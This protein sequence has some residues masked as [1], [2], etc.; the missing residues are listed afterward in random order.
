LEIFPAL[1]EAN[2]NYRVLYDRTHELSLGVSQDFFKM[3]SISGKRFIEVKFD[4][5]T[6][7]TDKGIIQI[8]FAT[9]NTQAN[10]ISVD[11]KG[12]SLFTDI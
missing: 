9:D 6:G 4:G 3:V 10:G 12:R 5:S 8:Y 1:E 7:G 2:V 11:F